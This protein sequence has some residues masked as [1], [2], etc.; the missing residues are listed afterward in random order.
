M[1]TPLETMGGA[2]FVSAIYGSSAVAVRWAGCW[3][4]KSLDSF[5]AWNGMWV[6]RQGMNERGIWIQGHE[7]IGDDGLDISL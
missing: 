4:F 6:C 2:A 1:I 5:W 7:G 3:L